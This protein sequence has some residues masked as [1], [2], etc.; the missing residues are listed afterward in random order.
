M[1]VAVKGTGRALPEKV[2][3]N[4]D[5]EKM[6]DTTDEWI[7][8]RT[9]MKER[10][11]GEKESVAY[12]AHKAC[13]AAL[14]NAG[15]RAEDVELIIVATCT[16]EMLLPCTGCRI[17][18]ML[19]AKD[20]I[21]FDIN[22]A[23]GGFLFALSTAYHYI[24]AGTCKNALV[25][26]SEVLS[27]IIDWTDRGTC[28]L[29]GDGAGAVYV[30]D[31]DDEAGVISTFQGSNGMLGDILYCRGRQVK[32]ETEPEINSDNLLV[33]MKGSE[34]YKFAVRQVPVCIRKA[35]DKAS[36]DV[37]DVD[38]FLL[39]QANKRIIESVAKTLKADS[40]RFPTNMDRIG[41]TSS[42]SIPILLDELNMDGA[43]KKGQKL[44]LSGFGAGMTFGALTMVW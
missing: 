28:V 27:E 44:V 4:F 11:I 8:V 42:A 9:G 34:V 41:N 7:T 20:A 3:T 32:A 33:H 15:K 6:V 24:K 1:G 25:V 29:F 43:I 40:D 35:L 14:E 12:L 36:W 10:H 5:L 30:E 38:M 13:V 21:A 18:N 2:L 31:C 19:G 39:H 16:T 22:A 37:S 26:G 23:C 17:Q